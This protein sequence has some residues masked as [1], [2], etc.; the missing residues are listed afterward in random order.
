ML[1]TQASSLRPCKAGA[2]FYWLFARWEIRNGESVI[3]GGSH[4]GVFLFAMYV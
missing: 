2:T 4:C 1:S 3:V